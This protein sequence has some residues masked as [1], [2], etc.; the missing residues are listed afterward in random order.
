MITIKH[1]FEMKRG[2]TLV[3]LLVVITIIGILTG[4]AVVSFSGAN[5]KAKIA[6]TQADEDTYRKVIG[7]YG[8]EYDV[9]PCP[10]HYY[11]G[12]SGNPSS[13]L[14]SALASYL[15]EGFPTAD[16]WGTQYVWHYHPGSAECT[17]LMSFGPNKTGDWGAEHNC[18][19]DDD[20]ID[21][22]F[23]RPGP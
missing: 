9:Y 19:Q 3:E 14:S 4:I 21:V 20:D 2:F 15:P 23:G 5:K 22:F 13:C 18:V 11:P 8:V 1:S 10:G 7:M 12:W 16:P 17:F 6:R